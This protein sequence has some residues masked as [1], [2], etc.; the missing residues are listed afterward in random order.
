M[1]VSQ[2][3]T[4]V[5][6][7]DLTGASR[8]VGLANESD[9]QKFLEKVRERIETHPGSDRLRAAL[10]PI[11]PGLARCAVDAMDELF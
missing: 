6:T 8:V 11:R 9:G 3:Y 4:V 10:R 2:R 1:A 7:N 5:I